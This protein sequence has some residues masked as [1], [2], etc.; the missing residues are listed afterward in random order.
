MDYRESGMLSSEVNKKVNAIFVDIIDEFSLCLNPGTGTMNRGKL[1][2]VSSKK[3][4]DYDDFLREIKR[5]TRMYMQQENES[6]LQQSVQLFPRAFRNAKRIKKNI[7]IIKLQKIILK[8]YFNEESDENISKKLIEF[9]N[10]IHR[11]IKDHDDEFIDCLIDRFADGM[12]FGL[13]QD[14]KKLANLM[15]ER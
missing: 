6:S 9:K 7:E 10:A 2:V 12:R 3:N 8:K 13:L 5:Y 4:M 15:N 14:L 1:D 11:C